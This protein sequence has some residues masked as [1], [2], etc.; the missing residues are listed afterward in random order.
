MEFRHS[1]RY[2]MVE[3]RARRLLYFRRMFERI[4]DVEGE[5]VECGVLYGES[6]MLLAFVANDEGRRRKLWGFD[7]FEPLSSGTEK[8]RTDTPRKLRHLSGTKVSVELVEKLLVDS[9]RTEAFVESQVTPVKG[10]FES[11]IDQFTGR[12]IALLHIDVD[13]Y[14][15]Y[16]TVLERLVPRM[17]PGGVI[18]FDEYMGTMEHAYFPGAQRAIDEYFGNRRSLIR[19]DGSTGKYYFVVER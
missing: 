10:Y 12:S 13:L 6:L 2:P 11:T 1:A 3:Q 15:S 9:G 19:R 17:E 7:S 5:V 16:K 18:M 8:D 4:A 14:D